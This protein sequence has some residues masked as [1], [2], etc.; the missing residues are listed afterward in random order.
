MAQVIMYC[1][2]FIAQARHQY[3]FKTRSGIRLFA[4]INEDMR[5]MIAGEAE[6]MAAA[7]DAFRQDKSGGAEGQDATETQADDTQKSDS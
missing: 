6:H 4:R 1:A 3:G 2:A 5:T 7:K